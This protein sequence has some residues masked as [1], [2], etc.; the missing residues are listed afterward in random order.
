MSRESK[1]FM[2]AYTITREMFGALSFGK[3]DD[4]GSID[5]PGIPRAP[6]PKTHAFIFYSN[7]G[8]PT[9]FGDFAQ[10]GALAYEVQKYSGIPVVLT[11]GPDD[12]HRFKTLY[13]NKAGTYQLYGAPVQVI[14][15]A[16]FNLNAFAV[17]GYVEVAWCKPNRTDY[18]NAIAATGAKC[19]FVGTANYL[20]PF[21]S[22]NSTYVNLVRKRQSCNFLPGLDAIRNGVTFTSFDSFKKDVNA[23]DLEMTV[24]PEKLIT[25]ARDYGLVYFKSGSGDRN[26]LI[27]YLRLFTA[28]KQNALII[29]IGDAQ[30]VSAAVK[31]YFDQTA[32]KNKVILINRDEKTSLIYFKRGGEPKK[33]QGCY[34][35]LPE[36]MGV[37]T[38]V[39][40]QSVSNLQMRRL[41]AG[42]HQFIAM[43]GVSS[44]I[45]A[46]GERKVVAY[47]WLMNNMEFILSYQR[48]PF[49]CASSR[50]LQDFGALL[51]KSQLSEA[52]IVKLMEYLQNKPLCDQLAALNA[53]MIA[54]SAEKLSTQLLAWFD[55]SR[56]VVEVDLSLSG[57]SDLP[58]EAA[59]PS[60]SSSSVLSNL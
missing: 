7:C 47:Q 46:W 32:S 10:C 56:R 53:R 42:A 40:C 19:A 39:T 12:I 21:A 6:M 52:N 5:N 54:E 14:S 57:S 33:I 31:T 15:T 48:N 29:A 2:F 8:N 49:F 24:L 50:M 9:A 1:N 30:S 37:T 38:I 35:A 43:T 23:D 13:G 28:V 55:I 34:E 22:P 16:E 27:N 18:V 36:Q 3:D 51:L 17:R 26:F 44:T 4:V 45:E 59:S 25:C 20:A 11:S 58:I 60:S 41:I